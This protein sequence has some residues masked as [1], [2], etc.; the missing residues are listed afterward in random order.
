MHRLA[1]ADYVVVLDKGQIAQQ[2]TFEQLNSKMGYVQS[3]N[4]EEL[5]EDMLQ[6]K[7]DGVD[8]IVVAKEF[9]TIP[10]PEKPGIDMDDERQTGDSAIYKYYIGSI[11][12]VRFLI[13]AVYVT[14]STVFVTVMPCE[15]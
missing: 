11:G 9:V 12:W 10:G 6:A 7:P 2:G 13:F 8:Q 3:L 15:C 1:A 4:I 5:K 14:V